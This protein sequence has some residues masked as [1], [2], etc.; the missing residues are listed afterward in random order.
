MRIYSKI[1]FSG[2]AAC[3]GIFSQLHCSPRID[4]LRNATHLALCSSAAHA[5][6]TVIP[7][8]GLEYT[9]PLWFFLLNVL[10]SIWYTHPISLQ[11]LNNLNKKTPFD[12]RNQYTGGTLLGISHS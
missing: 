11:L 9:I 6:P 12:P 7:G 1:D 4:V 2:A 10:I 3:L 5:Y 8:S